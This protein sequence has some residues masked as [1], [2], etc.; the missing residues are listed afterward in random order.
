MRLGK[1]IGKVTLSRCHP[2]YTGTKLRLVIPLALEDLPD[3]SDPQA[4]ALVVWDEIG[5]GEGSLIA[6]SEGPE[7]SQPFRPEI[8][9]IDAYASALIDELRLDQGLMDSIRRGK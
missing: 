4:D 7:A 1:V 6:I 9:P 3:A 2:S 8:K 5:T